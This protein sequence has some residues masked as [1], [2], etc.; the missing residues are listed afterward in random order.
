M[1]TLLEMSCDYFGIVSENL[2]AIY[3]GIQNKEGHYLNYRE[4]VYPIF[5]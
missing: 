5:S 3:D 1:G 2:V 4:Y